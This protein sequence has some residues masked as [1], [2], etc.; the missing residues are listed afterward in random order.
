MGSVPTLSSKTEIVIV[1]C[2]HHAAATIT[3]LFKSTTPVQTLYCYIYSEMRARTG[4]HCRI[5][6][7]CTRGGTYLE[8]T[9]PADKVLQGRGV[10]EFFWRAAYQLFRLVDVR[11]VFTRLRTVEHEVRVSHHAIPRQDPPAY[12]ENTTLV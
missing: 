8:I 12:I 4:E 1:K 9:R 3:T 6:C 5:P 10:S 7:L 11:F 2:Q